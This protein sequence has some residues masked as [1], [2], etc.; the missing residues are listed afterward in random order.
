[1]Q[2]SPTL[3]H[4]FGQ[5]LVPQPAHHAVVQRVERQ[6]AQ[7]R[8]DA[9]RALVHVARQETRGQQLRADAVR[10][11]L[12]QPELRGQL[13]QR[14]RAAFVGQQRQQPQAALGRRAG[15]SFTRHRRHGRSSNRGQQRR[16]ARARLVAC[17]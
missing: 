17:G 4:E 11:A 10:R 13:G 5:H 8:A 2:V 7:R 15:G 6:F 9:E 12:G 3:P 1:L 16:Q 14:Q